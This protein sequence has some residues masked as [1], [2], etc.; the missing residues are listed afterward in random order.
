MPLWRHALWYQR[1]LN[2]AEKYTF[3]G[4]QFLRH[5]QYGPIFIHLAA[6]LLAPKS[7]I[8]RRQKGTCLLIHP[9]YFSVPSI[10]PQCSPNTN[11]DR[12]TNPNIASF[13]GPCVHSYQFTARSITYCSMKYNLPCDWEYYCCWW[14][15]MIVEQCCCW[16]STVQS[17]RSASHCS[18]RGTDVQPSDYDLSTQPTSTQ[19]LGC[20]PTNSPTSSRTCCPPRQSSS[21]ISP[22]LQSH[23]AQWRIISN[24][25]APCQI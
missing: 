19:P 5:W 23:Q 25:P 14:R 16:R 24:L 15:R 7:A 4:L 6:A 8:S 20:C 17:S 21:P 18:R 12:N 2:T 22:H 9:N 10:I 13:Y 11:T 3:I 1:N